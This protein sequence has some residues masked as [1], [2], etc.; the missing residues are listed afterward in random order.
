[1]SDS[2]DLRLTHLG[3]TRGL[4][5]LPEEAIQPQWLPDIGV[6]PYRGRG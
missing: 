4:P 6:Q 2:Y 3:E 5:A 1:M